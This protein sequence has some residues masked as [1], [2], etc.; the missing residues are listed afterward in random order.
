[1]QLQH[2]PGAT[3]TGT[4]FIPKSIRVA[5]HL[6][7]LG[8]MCPF[9]AQQ[10]YTDPILALENIKMSGGTQPT[11]ISLGEAI[12]GRMDVD[13]TTVPDIIEEW[14]LEIQY[15]CIAHHLVLA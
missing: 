15:Y 2:N 8:L 5:F 9:V 3:I 7:R 13:E 12:N 6:P 4:H 11:F 1:M 10:L 14:R